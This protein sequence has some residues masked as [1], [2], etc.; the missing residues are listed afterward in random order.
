MVIDG[1]MDQNGLVIR[2]LGPPPQYRRYP[3]HLKYSQPLAT[4][5]KKLKK[6]SSPQKKYLW[7][8]G[9]YTTENNDTN[10]D[11]HKFVRVGDPK[12]RNCR[13]YNWD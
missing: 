8:G 3:I 11:Y 6:K 5:Y 2:K 10:T 4:R 13:N 7:V 12:T 9:V 1:F